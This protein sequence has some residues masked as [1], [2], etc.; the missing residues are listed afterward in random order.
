MGVELV[1]GEISFPRT[2]VRAFPFLVVGRRNRAV[3]DLNE[4][5]YIG[6]SF[7]SEW[8]TLRFGEAQYPVPFASR[9]QRLAFFE[10]I[11]AQ[12][13]RVKIYRAY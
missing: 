4:I 10:A 6:K 1:D 3:A 7:G 2:I 5:T 9:K 13:P 12:E 8:V 11:Q